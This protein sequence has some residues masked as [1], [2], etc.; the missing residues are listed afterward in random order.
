VFIGEDTTPEP[1]AQSCS[2]TSSVSILHAYREAVWPSHQNI[3]GLCE[4]IPAIFRMA[5]L[6]N[7]SLDTAKHRTRV[8]GQHTAAEM[9]AP[10]NSVS[11]AIMYHQPA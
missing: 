2:E 4:L 5:S 11:L 9:F 7:G 6:N 8:L 1:D 10:W 3:M